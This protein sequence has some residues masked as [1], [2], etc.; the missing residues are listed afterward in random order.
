[1]KLNNSNVLFDD[2]SHTYW[3]GEKKLYGI[4]R[5][6]G[7]QL[8]KDKYSNV[9]EHI[10]KRAAEKG[11]M[12][13][14][15]CYTYDM[16]GTI[17]GEDAASYMNLKK[18][19][20]FEVVESEYIVTDY[21]YF[22][23][24]IDK[25]ITINGEIGLADIKTTYKFDNEYLSWQLSIDA[26][27][28]ELVNPHIKVDKLFAIWIK[29]GAKLVT[30]QRK[31]NESILQLL[32]AEKTGKQFVNNE[33]SVSD[34]DNALSLIENLAE[35]A[36]SIENLKKTEKE[37][38]EKIEELFVNSGVSK[39]ETD[40]FVI[41]KKN[42]YERES[43]DSKKLKEDDEYVYNKYIK[44]ITVKGGIVTKLKK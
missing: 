44:K 26:Y 28:F 19:H 25:V 29:N 18:E 21:E 30:I 15:H 37:Y 7:S 42:D 38:R 43:F 17:L 8:F 10:L 33:I 11:K 23:T 41:T 1:M 4:T 24:A 40:Y 39:W 32:E 31:S 16:F 34:N 13:H 36:E 14:S 3:L 12:I 27:M 2:N 6:L 5:M 35:I 9:P 22:A 20:N